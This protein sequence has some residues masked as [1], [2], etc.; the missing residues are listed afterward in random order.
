[1]PYFPAFKL[2]TYDLLDDSSKRGE[3]DALI[4][5]LIRANTYFLY[6]YPNTP[7]I[8]QAIE[9]RR[10][11]YAFNYDTWKDIPAILEDGEGDCKDL[12]AWRIAWLRMAGI[13]ASADV[14]QRI[15]QGKDG[16]LVVYH[17]RVK[18]PQPD[19]SVIIEDPSLWAGMPRTGGVAPGMGI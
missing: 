11:K 14:P 16:P 17:V 6:S 19:G 5:V 18:V 9:Q 10:V 7:T 3:M 13:P 1:M 4:E 8:E 12:S 2:K 15:V